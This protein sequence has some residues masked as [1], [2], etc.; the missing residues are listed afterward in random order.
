MNAK[1]LVLGLFGVWIITQTVRGDLLG[2]LGLGADTKA[3]ATS[4]PGGGSW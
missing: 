1:G 3:N 4:S 2:L